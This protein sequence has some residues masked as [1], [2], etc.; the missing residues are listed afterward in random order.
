MI[1]PDS[2]RNKQ[3]RV[4]KSFLCPSKQGDLHFHCYFGQIFIVINTNFRENVIM[5]NMAFYGFIL[6]V[7]SSCFCFNSSD[8]LMV[9]V[10]KRI[11]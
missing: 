8:G 2:P 4:F 10:S 7:T 1:W 3:I 5:A 11:S 6:G 9:V